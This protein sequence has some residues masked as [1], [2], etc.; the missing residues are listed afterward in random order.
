VIR[1]DAAARRVVVGPREALRADRIALRDFNWLGDGPPEAA[2]GDGLPVFVK[3]RSTRAP[4]PAILHAGDGRYAIELPEGEEGV[5]PGQACVIYASPSGQ[6]RVLGG[7]VIE[8]NVQCE[9]A[10]TAGR[11]S[12]ARMACA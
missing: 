4:A 11:A 12:A 9:V 8:A 6:A 7:G 1:I 10:G 3:V 5:S 2:I